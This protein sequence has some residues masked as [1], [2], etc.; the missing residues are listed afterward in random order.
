MT[1]STTVITACTRWITSYPNTPTTPWAASTITTAS[2]N[3]M[4]SN[5]A[6]A[7]PPN[8][9]TS[10]SHAIDDSHWI[11]ATT[12]TVPPKAMRA[13]GS[14]AVPVRGPQVDR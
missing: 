8:S 12:A 7:S 14:W 1:I 9:P 6:S 11:T 2:Q 4:P 10:P 5:S 13:L 3:G